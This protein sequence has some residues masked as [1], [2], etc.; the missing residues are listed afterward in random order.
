MARRSTRMLTPRIAGFLSALAAAL[1]LAACAGQQAA[2]APTKAPEPAKPAAAS[3][4][5]AAAAPTAAPKAA[6]PAAGKTVMKIGHVLTESDNV[7]RAMVRFKEN[8]EKKTNGQVEVQIYPNS[9]LGSLRVTFESMQ[10]GNLEASVQDA[11]TPGTVAPLYAL[12]ELPYIFKDLDHVHRVLDGPLGAEMYKQL[13]DK[14]KVRTLAVYDTTFRKIFTKSK[15]IN[16]MADMKGLKIRVPEAPNYVSA[17]Q[18][19]GRQPDAS[20][21]GRAVHR[22][23]DRRGR[24]LREQGRGRLQRQAAR[25]GQVRGLHRPHLRAQSAAGE[26]QVVQRPA[27]GHAEDHHGRGD[28]RARPGSA[29]SPRPARR[30]TSRR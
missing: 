7:H 6:A 24:G 15:A 21:L 11:V 9:A 10:L 29:R 19:A 18:L 1:L 27:R 13:L 30:A 17:M 26:R 25:A 23:A 16:S 3:A 2:P 14:A 8:V 28:R 22:P 12:P 20:R 5:A 4:P